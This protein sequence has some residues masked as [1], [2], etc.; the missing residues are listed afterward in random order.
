MKR[1]S[2]LL[3]AS[4]LLAS[5]MLMAANSLPQGTIKITVGWAPGGGTDVFARIVGSK[6]SELWDRPVVVENKPGATG[7][8]AAEQF[9]KIRHSKDLNLLMAHVNTHAIAPHIFKTVTYDP[10]KDYAPIALIGA[11]PHLLVANDRYKGD[12]IADVVQMCKKAPGT[13]SFGSSG[14]G[15][16][17]HLAAEMFN[18]AAKVESIHVP[19][20]GSGPMHTD[21]IGG[22]IDFSFDTMTASTAQVKGGKLFAIAQTRLKRAKGFPDVPTM[23]EQGFKGFDA[24]SWYGVVGP[25]DMPKDLAISINTDINKVLLMPDVIERFD[26]YGVEDGGGSVDDFA[27]FMA[28]EYEK[29]GKVVRAANIRADS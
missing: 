16:V 1:R 6:L 24:S 3:G 15:S 21:L 23:D 11:T 28:V 9:S 4:A 29:W 7:M 18:M 22:Q 26:S 12:S 27:S 14:T 10:L 5:P 8:L 17:Q 20:R 25:A 2:F 19:Y 13:V